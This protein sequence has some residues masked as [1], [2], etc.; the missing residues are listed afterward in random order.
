MGILFF[1][2]RGKT[3]NSNNKTEK[4]AEVEILWINF[5]NEYVTQIAH[6][7]QSLYAMPLH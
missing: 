3:L 7:I 2:Y 6:F 4:Q 5:L 1:L